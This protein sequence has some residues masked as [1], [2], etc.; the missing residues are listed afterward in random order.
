MIHTFYKD[1]EI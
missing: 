1:L